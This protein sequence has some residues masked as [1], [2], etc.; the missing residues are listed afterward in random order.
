MRV[1]FGKSD[2]LWGN[3]T[4]PIFVDGK[5]IGAMHK[6]EDGTEWYTYGELDNGDPSPYLY[7]TDLGSTRREAEKTVRQIVKGELG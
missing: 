7:D 6:A 4:V 5:D 2:N 3:R 1:T